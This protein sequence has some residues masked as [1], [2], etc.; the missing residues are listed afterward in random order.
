MRKICRL[1]QSEC[2]EWIGWL[3]WNIPGNCGV[4]VRRAVLHMSLR[5]CG[6]RIFT[7]PGC[8]FTD[9]NRIEIGSRVSFVGRVL[10]R[11]GSDGILR[12]GANVAVNNNALIDASSGA[13]TIGQDC[14]IGPNVVIRAS[15]HVISRVDM[16]IWTLGHLSGTIVV[17][18][19][20]WIAAN[21][22]ILPNVKLG[23]GCVVAAG[24][25]V[26]SSVP[27]GAIVGGVPARVLRYR[28]A[29]E[30]RGRAES[31]TSEA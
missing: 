18:D 26:T 29:G 12:I 4:I 19:D 17:D 25:V 30:Q 6:S 16:P 24:A 5:N 28:G 22:V 2:I 21:A 13:I 27:A 31:C 23:K 1:I 7:A 8:H 3:V 9:L 10:L 11:A 14:L 15:N 20:V